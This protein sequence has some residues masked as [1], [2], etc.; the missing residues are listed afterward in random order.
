MIKITIFK[1]NR[2]QNT[3]II[4]IIKCFFPFFLFTEPNKVIDC[5]E[6]TV[7]K[8]ST[9]FIA[10]PRLYNPLNA[11]NHLDSCLPL[12]VPHRVPIIVLD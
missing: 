3:K 9:L 7:P 8:K 5:S 2:N 12:L 11:I 10:Q 4:A 1:I 6:G